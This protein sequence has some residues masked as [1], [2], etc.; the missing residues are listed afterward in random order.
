M[1]SKGLSPLKKIK[2]QNVNNKAIEN[3][4]IIFLSINYRFSC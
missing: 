4:I 2:K 3:D 1:I